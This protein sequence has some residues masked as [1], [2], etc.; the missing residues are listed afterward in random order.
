VGSVH[1]GLVFGIRPLLGR[2]AVRETHKMTG[3]FEPLVEI[4]D[5]CKH[6]AFWESWSHLVLVRAQEWLN[7]F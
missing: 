5:L 6:L 1:V 7:R 2:A 3:A 4:R